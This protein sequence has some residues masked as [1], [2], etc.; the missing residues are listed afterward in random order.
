MEDHARTEQLEFP[1]C[2]VRGNYRPRSRPPG[3][4]PLTP[5][6]GHNVQSPQLRDC[7]QPRLDAQHHDPNLRWPARICALW[8]AWFV[9]TKLVVVSGGRALTNNPLPLEHHITCHGLAN[10]SGRCQSSHATGRTRSSCH[11]A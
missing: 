8:P 1:I 7:R 10:R 2:G 9:A 3:V 11:R 5:F 6:I 4:V